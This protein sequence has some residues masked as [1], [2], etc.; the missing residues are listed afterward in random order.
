M[1]LDRVTTGNDVPNEI[2]VVI[3]IPMNS[4]PIK[5]EL[6]KK[7][8]AMFVDRFVSTAMHY[9][10]NYGYIPH[11]LADDGDPADVLV[12][13][14]F[15]VMPGVVV[16]CRPVGML[17]M[18]DEGGGD[19]KLLAVPIEKL[20]PLYR[21]VQSPQDFV[22]LVLDQIQ[23]FFAHYKDL[24]PDKWVKIEGWKDADAAKR[25]IVLSVERYGRSDPKPVY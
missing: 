15:P 11:T 16:R 25:E 5:Y 6:D 21:H 10:C 24:E 3:E 1:N 14:P 2:N 20:S 23:H 12:V 7:T 22:P 19:T 18:S 9:P 8:G 13:T 17:L 4:D